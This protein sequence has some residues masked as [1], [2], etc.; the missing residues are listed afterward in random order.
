MGKTVIITGAAAGIGFG[1]ACSFAEEK[2]RVVLVDLNQELLDKAESQL[3]KQDPDLEILTVA[4]DLSSAYGRAALFDRVIEADI[5]VN[6][7]GYYENIDFF[8]LQESNWDK[9]INLNFMVA[10]ALSKFYFKKMLE[11]KRGRLIFISSESALNPDSEKIHYC[12]AKTMLLSLSRNL[13]ELTRNTEV[14]V[15]CILPGP[16]LTA[17]TERFIKERYSPDLKEAEKMFMGSRPTSLI[18]RLVRP[19]E[20]GSAA[21]F[22]ADNKSGAIN[23]SNLKVEGG[24]VTGII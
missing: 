17:G 14:T 4:T 7:L 8:D 22:L 9:M 6:N 3:L 15:N 11:K 16:A 5:L 23:G 19:E 12:V 10:M 18:G 24:I 13:A 2:Y 20:I 1:I 21:V